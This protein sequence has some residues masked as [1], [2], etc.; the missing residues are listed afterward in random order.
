MSANISKNGEQHLRSLQ[1]GRAVFVN[2]KSIADVTTDPSYRNAARSIAGL[3]EFQ[4]KPENLELMTFEVPGGKRVN[5]A[6]QLPK[7]HA[8]LVER[9][10]ALTAWA[11]LHQGFMGRS[12]DHVASSISAMLIGSDVYEKHKGGKAGNVREY[13][14]YARDNDLY[15]SYVIIDPQGDR[16][17]AT[18]TGGNADLAVSIC[19]EDAEGI[20]VRGSKMLGTGAIL[21]N[22][23]LVT[24][25]RPLA[26][27]E[28]AYA[29]TAA[30][31]INAKGLKLMS[32]RSYE[33]AAP[34]VFDYPLSSRFD[35][36]DA[37]LYFDEVKIP[38]DRVFVH[39]DTD[40][41]LAQW[42]VAPTHS[43]QNYQAAIRL[44]V[45]L[46]FLVGLA[47]KITEAIGTIN[48]PSV[49]ETLGELSS[50][51]STIEAYVY[52]MET[53]GHSYGEY[54]MPNKDILYGAQVYQQ[55][56]YPRVIATIRELAGGG[57]LMLPSSVEDFQNPEIAD[58]IARTQY[59]ATGDAVDRVK[60]FKLAWDALG[61]EFASRH[62]QYEMFYSGPRTVTT[63]MAYRNFNW[64]QATGMVGKVLAGY[65][66]PVLAKSSQAAAAE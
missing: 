17:K 57:V 4:S 20:T 24:T 52:A 48:F 45:K 27:G 31:P 25:L 11:E 40:A 28:E 55:R 29:F 9:R 61:S 21:S 51:V 59:S 16:S 1:D 63:N 22:E 42:H 43:Y 7:S 37:L 56:L 8:D 3:Y 5:R 32:R 12:P 30:V 23:V 62:S 66:S 34:S 50:E 33:S 14:K 58:V 64:S 49:R 18:G 60:L 6:W 65:P 46:R 38:W 44:M 15:L 53:A 10:K 36:N 39:R 2:G 26:K 41:Q 35:E 19:D 13:Y 47:H 54:F